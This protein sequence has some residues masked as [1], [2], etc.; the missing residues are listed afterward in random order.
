MRDLLHVQPGKDS[1]H[2]C[3]VWNSIH[4]EMKE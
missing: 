2:N 4:K 3:L 1:I